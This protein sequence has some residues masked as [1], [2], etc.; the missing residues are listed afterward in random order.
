MDEAK[1]SF[2]WYSLTFVNSALLD[3]QCGMKHKCVLANHGVY[4]QVR[5]KSHSLHS[6]GLSPYPAAALAR[7]AVPGPSEHRVQVHIQ[8]LH[9]HAMCG[10]L[11][12]LAK[13]VRGHVC[14]CVC[15]CVFVC[16]FV[17]VVCVYVCLCVCVCVCVWCV[18]M[19]SRVCVCVCVRERERESVKRVCVCVRA[20]SL[21]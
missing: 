18:C 19:F 6:P 4:I 3:Q 10:W 5:S 11:V 2:I 9:A 1:Q 7:A 15:L 13:P 14:V 12:E 21:N 17:C 8:R 16:V 20:L